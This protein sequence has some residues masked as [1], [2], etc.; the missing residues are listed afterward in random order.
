[1]FRMVHVRVPSV[2]SGLFSQLD[3]IAVVF[4]RPAHRDVLLSSG[5]HA[6][7]LLRHSASGPQQMQAANQ[8]RNGIGAK[9]DAA[10]ADAVA[11]GVF[12]NDTV[13]G[14]E[15]FNCIAVG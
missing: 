8:R 12:T 3:V 10:G 13:P 6:G 1:M 5:C 7:M 15:C 11:D 9:Y 4:N 2:V 14:D